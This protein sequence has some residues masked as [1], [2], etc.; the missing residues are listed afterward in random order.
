MLFRSDSTFFEMFSF[1]LAQ[2][3]PAHVLDR[4]GAAV[5]SAEAAQKYFGDENPVARRL[6]VRLDDTFYDVTV[7]GVAQPLP[8]NSSLSFDVLLSH[9]SKAGSSSR[10][11][12]DA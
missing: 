7:T 3:D 8:P 12:A 4:P 2:G 5:L 9:A 10:R 1:P 11:S 6:E